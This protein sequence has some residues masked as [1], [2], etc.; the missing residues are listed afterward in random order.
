M[1]SHVRKLSQPFLKLVQE[2]LFVVVYLSRNDSSYA[3]SRPYNKVWCI[4]ISGTM[5][6]IVAESGH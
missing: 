6:L 2:G 5:D 3:V 1:S 4:P